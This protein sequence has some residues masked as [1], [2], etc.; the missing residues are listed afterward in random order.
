M[1]IDNVAKDVKHGKL[2]QA[3]R[4]KHKYVRKKAQYYKKSLLS[5]N[6][7]TTMFTFI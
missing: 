7:I 6:D 3:F 5:N 4:Q 1:L 2:E